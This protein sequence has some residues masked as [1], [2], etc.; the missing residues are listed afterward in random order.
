MP[1]APPAHLGIVDLAC[2]AARSIAVELVLFEAFGRWV[3][4]TMEAST[5]PLLAAASRRHAWRAELWRERFPVIPDADVDGAVTAERSTLRA[6]VD[7]LATF[8]ALPSGAGRM[9][10]ADYVTTELAREYQAILAAIDPLLD[11][12]T[13]RVLALVLAD[14]DVAQPRVG[15]LADAEQLALEALQSARFP[16]LA[17]S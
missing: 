14:L 6:L 5:K 3:P 1:V 9:A 11:A 17:V 8:D 15:P 12:P 7:A 10:V 4:T 2:V 13:A 16:T